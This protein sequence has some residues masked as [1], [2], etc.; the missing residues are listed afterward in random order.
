MLHE[1]VGLYDRLEK[2]RPCKD[3]DEYKKAEEKCNA[4]SNCITGRK[5]CGRAGK[6]LGK[7]DE[8]TDVKEETK[9]TKQNQEK[10]EEN[11]KNMDE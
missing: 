1:P 11:N 10:R 8:R 3:D 4:L 6:R 5:V 9:K 7:Y 2:C